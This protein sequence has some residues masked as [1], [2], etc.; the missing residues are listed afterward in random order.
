MQIDA[1]S[2]GNN[3]LAGVIVSYN[4]LD[5]AETDFLAMPNT[6]Y[7]TWGF[8]AM[9]SIDFSPNTGGQN[10]SVH[11][12]PWV[13]GQLLS[14]SDIPTS[15]TATMSG[16]A[17]MSTAFRHNQ[18]GSIYDVHK[19]ISNGSVQVQFNWDAGG[20]YTGTFSLSD[21]DET[22]P[23]AISAGITDFN[24]NI[25]GSGVS[26][27]GNK[28]SFNNGWGGSVA[29]QGLL[30]GGNSPD[31]SGGRMNVS[32]SK[33]GDINTSGANDFYFAEGIFLVD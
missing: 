7:S 17:I 12:A 8:W 13:A 9:S 22:N 3:N 31:E 28:T 11:L 15:G 10:V 16:S 5:Q 21:Y 25:T 2:G 6:D 32:L 29:V 30:Y 27:S 33:T 4:T 19:Y 20:N 23:I 24:F 1:S 14:V 26:Y 18:S